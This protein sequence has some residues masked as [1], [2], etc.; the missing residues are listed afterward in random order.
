MPTH[1]APLDPIETAI[2]PVFEAG[3]PQSQ[4][5]LLAKY[6]AGGEAA[7]P[8]IRALQPQL[9]AFDQRRLL[10]SVL[11]RD[12]ARL[13]QA[14]SRL[15]PAIRGLEEAAASPRM[16]L[17]SDWDAAPFPGFVETDLL[18]ASAS[19][20][21]AC[22]QARIALG[23][24]EQATRL[25]QTIWKLDA[26]LHADPYGGFGASAPQLMESYAF[27]AARLAESSASSDQL[28]SMVAEMPKQVVWPD[29][30]QM[31]ESEGY[32]ALAAIRNWT[33][34][35]AAPAILGSGSGAS[36]ESFRFRSERFREGIPTD[37]DA[38]RY[39]RAWAALFGHL[40]RE[41]ERDGNLN[42]DS[43]SRHAW[44]VAE[45]TPGADT[46]F[47]KLYGPRYE[48]RFERRIFDLVRLGLA[49]VALR[50]GAYRAR[51]GSWPPDLGTAGVTEN[52]PISERAFGYSVE[53]ARVRIWSYGRNGRDDQGDPERDMVLQMSA[54]R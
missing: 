37:P 52:D 27:A 45:G 50:L 22:V 26:L 18:N 6:P 13:R 44:V 31:F 10:D 11:H 9:A 25:W 34:D 24:F 21:A 40:L 8:R 1:E 2:A 16:G 35:P 19:M 47:L 41:I 20:L 33:K 51:M 36:M 38:Q 28:S 53:G 7:A 49:R 32:A 5:Q 42:L 17:V 3:M 43:V 54:G 23:D 30:R 14:L 29:F 39:V 48:E 46:S 12:E 15:E 4:A